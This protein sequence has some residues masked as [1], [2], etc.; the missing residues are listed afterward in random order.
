[1]N[2]E[3]SI[4]NA[5][6]RFEN[7]QHSKRVD[8]LQKRNAMKKKNNLRKFIV[9]ELLIK[10]FPE[11]SDFEPGTKDENFERFKPLSNFLEKISSE[12]IVLHLWQETIANI[13][14]SRK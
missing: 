2:L 10:F 3:D 14:E 12:E 9:D 11:I 7:A 6:Q 8:E 5:K 4:K 13:N 1:L